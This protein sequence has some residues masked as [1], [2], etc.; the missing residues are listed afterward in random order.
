MTTMF[1][2]LMREL[3][4]INPEFPIQYAICLAEISLNDEL[5]LTEL[6]KRTHMP[7]STVSRIVGALSDS[8][9]RGKP[10]NLVKVAICTTE[11]RRK[12]LSLTTKG[13][14]VIQGIEDVLGE[15]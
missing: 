13:K 1:L 6:S 12:N 10:Y 11:R 2:K 5:S 4:K 14:A 7:L 15:R 8:R 3:Q 9:Q